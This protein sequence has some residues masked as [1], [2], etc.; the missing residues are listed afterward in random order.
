LNIWCRVLL[1]YVQILLS[2]S[3]LDQFHFMYQM[4]CSIKN[5]KNLNIWF[6]ENSKNQIL[7]NVLLIEK[8]GH[9]LDKSPYKLN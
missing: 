6:F 8:R 3:K 5:L 4:L 7:N 9:V 1:L 2:K